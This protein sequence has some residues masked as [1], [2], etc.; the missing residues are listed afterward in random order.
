MKA[1]R[2]QREQ[3]S[4]DIMGYPEKAFM[5]MLSQ[6]KLTPRDCRYHEEM[7]S[8]HSKSTGEGPGENIAFGKPRR[9]EMTM[10]V[11]QQLSTAAELQ[12]RRPEHRRKLCL[13]LP[14]QRSRAVHV[15]WTLYTKHWH[16]SRFALL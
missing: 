5:K 11:G 15:L 13:G 12:W 4:L 8:W 16:F 1:L 14:T 9:V 6:L 3:L 2:G 10:A 7:L